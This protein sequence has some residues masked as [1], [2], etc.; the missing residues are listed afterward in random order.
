MRPMICPPR[1]R[2]KWLSLCLLQ[3]AEACTVRPRARW[4]SRR[5]DPRSRFEPFDPEFP[6]WT[7]F[8][9]PLML[10]SEPPALQPAIPPIRNR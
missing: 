3:N 9:L 2:V 4:M 8:L 5:R 6:I 7:H 10:L 1:L